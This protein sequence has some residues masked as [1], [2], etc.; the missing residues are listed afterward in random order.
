MN[1]L[2]NGNDVKGVNNAVWKRWQVGE[3]I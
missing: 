1:A 2:E 3:K